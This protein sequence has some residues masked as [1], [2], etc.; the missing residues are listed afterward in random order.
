MRCWYLNSHS[1]EWPTGMAAQEEAPKLMRSQSANAVPS[2]T[3]P[4]LAPVHVRCDQGLW[5]FGKDND[6]LRDVLVIEN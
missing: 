5:S 1:G 4:D 3:P 6:R 2:F